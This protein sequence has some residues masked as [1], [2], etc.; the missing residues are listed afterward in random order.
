MEAVNLLSSNKYTEKQIVC[1]QKEKNFFLLIKYFFFQG[2][3]IYFCHYEF[4]YGNETI[5]YSKYSK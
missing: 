4:K 2:L 1:I 3:F 5:N